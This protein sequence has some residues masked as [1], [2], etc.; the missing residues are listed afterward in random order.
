MVAQNTPRASGKTGGEEMARQESQAALELVRDDGDLAASGGP[1]ERPEDVHT[2]LTPTLHRMRTDWNSSD[3]EIIAQMRHAV[4]GIVKERF[5]DLFELM[6]QVYL[7]VREP[8]VDITSGE[9]KVDEWGLPEWRRNS[10]GAY[11]E[12]WSRMTGREREDYL[13]RI[14]TGLFAWEQRAADLWGEALFSKAA[15]EEAFS[16]GYEQLGNPRATIEDRTARARILAAE[17]RY[18]A[19]YLSYLSKR[20]DAVVRAADRLGQRIKDIHVK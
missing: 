15:F 20:A 13:Y 5:A 2:S 7:L 10:R 14:T 17:H 1:V 4:D 19:V 9:I 12:D 16:H 18:R 8:D 11:V 3:R 6:Y